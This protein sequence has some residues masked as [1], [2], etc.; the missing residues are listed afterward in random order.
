LLTWDDA[1]GLRKCGYEIGSHTL[2]HA[3]LTRR[4][5]KETTEAFQRRIR[6]EIADSKSVIEQHLGETIS[7]IAYPN[8][9]Y[10]DFVLQTAQQEGYSAGCTTDHGPADSQSSALR[11]P[12]QM[13]MHNTPMKTIQHACALKALHLTNVKPVIG[14]HVA[15]RSASINFD[16]ES[17]VK[18]AQILKGIRLS[19]GSIIKTDVK[20]QSVSLS[21]RLNRGASYVIIDGA[22]RGTSWLVICDGQ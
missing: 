16:L 5:P 2:S 21:V 14:A 3:M 19:P 15:A 4:G 9:L 8:G 12:R 17:G 22:G 6:K 20:G 18:P 10:D 13:V 11:L 7:S 1:K